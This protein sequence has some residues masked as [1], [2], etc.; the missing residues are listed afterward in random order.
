MRLQDDVYSTIEILRHAGIKVWMLTGDKIETAMVNSIYI[1]YCDK[2]GNQI[3]FI[4]NIYHQG[5]CGFC[6]L[7]RLNTIICPKT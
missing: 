6:H 3:E 1:V 7:E 4:R 2:H 5:L